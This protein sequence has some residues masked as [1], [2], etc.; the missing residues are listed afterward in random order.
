MVSTFLVG[1]IFT[2][3]GVPSL[4]GRGGG[5][6]FYFSRVTCFYIPWSADTLGFDRQLAHRLLKSCVDILLLRR[7]FPNPDGNLWYH[8]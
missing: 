6:G 2:C 3:G 7:P 8:L 5:F 4:V 1:L